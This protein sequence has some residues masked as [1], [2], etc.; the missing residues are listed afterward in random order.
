MA[1][2]NYSDVVQALAQQIV[3]VCM[4]LLK[5]NLQ[6]LLA[7]ATI[8]ADQIEGEVSNINTTNISVDADRVAGLSQYVS[9]IIGGS[10]IDI[11]KLITPN[12]E[13]LVSIDEDGHI[14]M[15]QVRMNELQVTD[16][17]Q[18][19]Y[20]EIW[21]TEIGKADIQNA[22]INALSARFAAIADTQIGRAQID[23][24]QITGLTAVK[25]DIANALIQNAS[26]DFA[27]IRALG[28]DNVMIGQGLGGKLYIADLAVTEANMVSLTVGELVVKDADGVFRSLVI[29]PATG[30]VTGVPKPIETINLS[31]SA[32]TGDK[33]ANQ[34]IDGG[35]KII[36]RSITAETLNV[37]QIFAENAMVLEM[38]AQNANIGALFATDAFITHLNAADISNNTS[39]RLY[40]Q[41]SHDDAVHQAELMLA[42][43]RIISTVTGSTEFSDTI[44]ER[45][46]QTVT[47]LYCVGENGTEPPGIDAGWTAAIPEATFGDYLWT[48]TVTEYS[49][50]QPSVTVY[51]VTRYGAHSAD[52][53]IVK[54]T[55]DI[56]F[57]YSEP[58]GTMTLTA[59]VYAGGTLLAQAD[60]N[61]LGCLQWFKNGERVPKTELDNWHQL[62]VDLA[63]VGT[64]AVYSVSLMG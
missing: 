17:F 61:A 7:G 38:M 22:V 9:S 28:A 55:S 31:D 15:D 42:D 18:A 23:T 11:T 26:I 54:T 60:V 14:Y 46:R 10:N 45:T 51:N 30:E 47:T 36:E 25:A 39:L 29:D 41:N 16:I 50:G 32:V 49:N 57:T 21:Q 1:A 12:A 43:D 8:S 24:A 20:A 56:G 53:I 34:T 6:G 58:E 33:I 27:Q 37:R 62:T 44:N 5:R 3:D 64:N 19:K 13:A 52:G 35:S 63:T 40:V 4:Q 2:D 48:K 59:D